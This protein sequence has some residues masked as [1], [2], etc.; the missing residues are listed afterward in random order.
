[1]A[2][3][4][5]PAAS[6]VPAQ[7][8]LLECVFFKYPHAIMAHETTSCSENGQPLSKNA[9]KKLEKEREKA[10]RKAEREA[11]EAAD[12]A[13]RE[14]AEVDYAT[15]NYGK[16]PLNQSQERTGELQS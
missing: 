15:Q 16:A 5:S 2:D 13:A 14:A 6:S 3:S 1:M 4:K 10:Q 12:R 8:P 11:K 9:I 7:G